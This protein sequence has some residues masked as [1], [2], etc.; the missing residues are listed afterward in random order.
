MTAIE[1]KIRNLT[2]YLHYNLEL[3]GES[4][5]IGASIE[6]KRNEI[7]EQDKCLDILARLLVGENDVCASV[8]YDGEKL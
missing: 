6:P 7:K 5:H 4:E 2:D 1:E 8:C 3:N